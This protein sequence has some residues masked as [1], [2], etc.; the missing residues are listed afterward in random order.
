M[1]KVIE[2]AN[3]SDL[4]ELRLR[5]GK[6]I[7]D[8]TQ[9]KSDI[10]SL[11]LWRNS[12][13]GRFFFQLKTFLINHVRLVFRELNYKQHRDVPRFIRGMAT[14]FAAYP[15][16]GVAISQVRKQLMGETLTT[17]AIDDAF[18]DPTFTNLLWGYVAAWAGAGAIGIVS[19]IVLT[20]MLNNPYLTSTLAIAP[21]AG[22]LTN[23]LNITA[24]VAAGIV[25]ADPE[26]FEKAARLAARE[27]GGIGAIAEKEFLG[28]P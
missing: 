17:D 12:L 23:G 26:K 5:A 25:T 7:S 4:A 13:G 21:A 10:Q 28:E 16:A 8:S 6:V 1:E 20:M 9:F 18:N 11:P 2:K 24:S 14:F 27:F 22:T 15:A 3:S 19:D